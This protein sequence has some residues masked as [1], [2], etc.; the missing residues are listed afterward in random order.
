MLCIAAIQGRN[1]WTSKN[2]HIKLNNGSINEKNVIQAVSYVKTLNAKEQRYPNSKRL[3]SSSKEIR[4]K[5]N[6]IDSWHYQ[7]PKL[8]AV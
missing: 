3:K 4:T 2:T 5:K 6:N 7:K 8:S 1:T